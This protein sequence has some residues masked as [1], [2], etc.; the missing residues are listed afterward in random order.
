[1]NIARTFRRASLVAG[2]LTLAVAASAFAHECYNP[3]A[4]AQ[5]ALAKA[6]H[7]QTWVLAADVREIISTGGSG[8]FPAGSFPVLNSCQQDAFLAAYAKTG[9]PLVFTT[10]DKQAVGQGGTI[11]ENNPNMDAKLGFDG[12]GIDHFELTADAIFA[13]I[14]DS[15]NEAF[16]SGCPA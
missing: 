6:E 12:K 1:M 16:G 4:S 7:S 13:A 2:V 14:G 15:Y 9:F 8:F 5:G 11:A 3:S 10:A